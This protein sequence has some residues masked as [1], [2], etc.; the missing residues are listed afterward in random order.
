MFLYCCIHVSSFCRKERLGT[1]SLAPEG[2]ASHGLAASPPTEG[3]Y[4][5]QRVP[6]KL[7]NNTMYYKPMGDPP[8]ISSEEGGGL[9]T[10]I[11]GLY[12]HIPNEL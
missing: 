10:R 9:I 11:V 3:T 7:Y 2:V 8:Y 4:V 1:L 5:Q 6:A 12:T